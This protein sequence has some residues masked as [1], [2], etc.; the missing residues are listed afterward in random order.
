[1]GPHDKDYSILGSVMGYPDFGKLP[2][3]LESKLLKGNYTGENRG[4]YIRGY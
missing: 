3:E 1:M 4:E 2:Y